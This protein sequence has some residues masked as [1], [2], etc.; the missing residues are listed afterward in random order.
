MTN[1][2]ED[3]NIFMDVSHALDFAAEVAKFKRDIVKVSRI[4]A[5]NQHG[6]AEDVAAALEDA[7]FEEDDFNPKEEYYHFTT[8]YGGVQIIG[9][10]VNVYIDTGTDMYITCYV[11]RI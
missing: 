4:V 10:K 3:D 5:K 8:S 6:D 1:Y 2:L 7:G 11:G 9:N